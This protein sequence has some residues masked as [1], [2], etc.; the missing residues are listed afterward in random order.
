MKYLFVFEDGTMK[1]Q[2]KEPTDGDYQYVEQGSGEIIRFENGTFQ[3]ALVE[4]T[5]EYS[6]EED[7]D[8]VE[9]EPEETVNVEW[10]DLES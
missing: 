5:T 1:Q 6:P 2:D 8:G 7:E 10:D 4:T 3:R 9:T